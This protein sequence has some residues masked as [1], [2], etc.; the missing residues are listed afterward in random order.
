MS[1]LFTIEVRVNPKTETI[2]M[3]ALTQAKCND[4]TRAHAKFFKEDLTRFVV[5][6]AYFN[7]EVNAYSHDPLVGHHDLYPAPIVPFG[8]SEFAR[9][10]G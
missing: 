6:P 2:I 5:D 9:T 8:K 3:G 7:V 10:T 4:M 1:Y